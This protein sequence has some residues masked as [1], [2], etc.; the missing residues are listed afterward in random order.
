MIWSPS[1]YS[2]TITVGGVHIIG[3]TSL[4]GSILNHLCSWKLPH[5]RIYPLSICFFQLLGQ[6]VSC[7]YPSNKKINLFWLTDAWE[8]SNN[9]HEK[10]ALM[11]TL[12]VPPG[13]PSAP[14]GPSGPGGPYR[15]SMC[16]S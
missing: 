12:T 16:K 15:R 5:I 2:T 6:F 7:N 3:R 11:F 1:S 9:L 4:H 10:L 14:A 8:T 13:L